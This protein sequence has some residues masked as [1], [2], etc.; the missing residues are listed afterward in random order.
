MRLLTLSE[1]NVETIILT[2][3]IVPDKKED[4]ADLLDNK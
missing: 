3:Y 2:T 1:E 4:E